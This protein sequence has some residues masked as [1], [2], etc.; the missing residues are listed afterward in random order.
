VMIGNSFRSDI[1]PVVESG[2]KAIHI[3]YETEWILDAISDEEKNKLDFI[4]LEKITQVP[5]WLEQENSERVSAKSANVSDI[6]R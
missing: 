4:S 3:A 6:S 2:G 1:M 5:D